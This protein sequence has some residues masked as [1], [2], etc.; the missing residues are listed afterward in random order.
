MSKVFC[1]MSGGVDSSVAASLL[2]NQGYQVTGVFMKCWSLE[3]LD[4]LKIPR[5]LYGCFWEDDARDAELVA[6]K[7]NIPF[8]IWDLQEEYM[9]KVVNYMVC[10]YK[11]GRTPNPD[12]MCN[13][14]IKFGIFYKKAKSLGA[15]FVA[16]GHYASKQNYKNNPAIAKGK[17]AAKDQSYF[18]WKISSEV[19]SDILFPLEIFNTKQEV[20]KY[21]EENNLITAKKPDSQGLCFIGSTPLRHMLSSIYGTKNGQIVTNNFEQAKNAKQ[22]T[23][24]DKKEFDNFGY[25]TIGS[26]PGASLY[27]I[28]QRNNLGL[29]G[30]PWFVV[31][32]DVVKNIVFVNHQQDAE[33]LLQNTIFIKDICLQVPFS[34]LKIEEDGLL[35]CQ[36]QIRYHGTLVD[37]TIDFETEN[38]KFLSPKSAIVMC[39][40][41]VQAVAYGQSLVFYD[42]EF[43]LGGGVISEKE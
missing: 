14:T 43:M 15:D 39:H 5:D 8:E 3:Q 1:M 37:C 7:L 2:V 38:N 23:K 16:T 30:G 42:Q 25:V 12:V 6:K 21:A 41:P 22:L 19:I 36:C 18:L 34:S 4:K 35:H 27:T 33:I 13:S 26:H 17:D 32:T 31:K 40:K 20:R 10:E 11:I 29:S 28:G 9:Q 24:K